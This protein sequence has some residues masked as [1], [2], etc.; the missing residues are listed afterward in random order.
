MPI[1]EALA[2]RLVL[3]AIAAPLFL[4]SGPDL[5]VA[6]CRAGIVGTFPALN[7]RP[8][9]VLNDWLRDIK[10]R[11][12]EPG[13]AG[14]GPVAPFGV[15]LIVHKTNPRAAE[16]LEIVIDHEV[17]LVITS[18]GNP[19]DTASRIH[20]YGGLVFHD[21]TNTHHAHKAAE[22]DVDGLILVC[23]GAGGHGGALSPFAL[24]GEVR[25][26]WDKTIVL[27]GA[28]SDGRAIRAAEV[29]G[30][31]LAYL[32]TRFVATEESLAVPGFKEMV[33]NEHADGIIYTP[34]VTGIPANFLRQSLVDSGLD[35]DNLPAKG[36]ISVSKEQKAWS[37]VWSAGQ[38]VGSI[39][40]AP[41]VAELVARLTREYREACNTPD[42]N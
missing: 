15:N 29:M 1:P 30:A 4:V 36:A 41:P 35:P 22:A 12:A 2:G 14:A 37:D 20:A 38:G 23:A 9:G 11:L 16:D 27:A 25:Q 8:A 19:G 10:A 7:A 3:P 42:F 17:P 31:D 24:L 34:A 40:D 6:A 32:G 33:V 26:F 13:P 18:V 21:V 5:V 39:H 28:I